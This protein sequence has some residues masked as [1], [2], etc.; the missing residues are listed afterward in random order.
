MELSALCCA[1]PALQRSARAGINGVNNVDRF[2]YVSD[3][4][5]VT[6]L[7]KSWQQ[8]R[9]TLSLTFRYGVQVRQNMIKLR[10][11]IAPVNRPVSL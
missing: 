6:L 9:E 5:N 8:K 1:L 2:R 7:S 3:S 11:A 4:S 10:H